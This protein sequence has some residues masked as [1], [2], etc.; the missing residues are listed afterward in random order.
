MASILP[1]EIPLTDKQ[2]EELERYVET[3]LAAALEAHDQR[4]EKYARWRKAYRAKPEVERKTFPWDG[5]SNMVIPIVGITVDT[6]VARLMRGFFSTPTPVEAQI[7]SVVA[8]TFEKDF[9]DWGELFFK[10]SGARDQTRS[11]FH[12]MTLDGTVFVKAAWDTEL[13]PVHAYNAEGGEISYTEVVDY[14]GVRWYA[15]PAHNMIYPTGFSEWKRLPWH[16]ERLMF[17]WAEL[18]ELRDKGYTNIDDQL[19]AQRSDRDSKVERANEETS[20]VSH[21]NPADFYEMFELWGKFPIP[22]EEIEGGEEPEPTWQECILTF[23]MKDRRLHRAI[24]N[25]FFGR[26]RCIIRIPFLH[27]PHEI[28]GLGAA[29]QVEQ[30]QVEA[31]TAH[32]QSID[33]AT[34]AI[35][36]IIVKKPNVTSL[37]G[38]SIHPGAELTADD[39]KND[40]MVIHL[41][42]GRSTLPGVEQQAAFWAEKRSGVSAY[43]MGVESG[44]AGSRATATGTTAL[45]SEGNMRF[46]VSI[47]DMREALVDLLYLT[48]Q[49]EQQYRPE[50]IPLSADRVLQLPQG[51]L[52][53]MFGLILHLSSEKI[54]RDLEIQNFQ[55]LITILNDYYARV[56]QAAALIMN[57][58]FP[59]GQ[60]F[61]IMQVMEAAHNLVKRLVERFDIQNIDEVVPGLTQALNMLGGISAPPP[62]PMGALPGG[63]PQ[64]P[65]GNPGGGPPASSQGS[66]FGGG[67]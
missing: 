5:A 3:Q 39:P 49:L 13:R 4:E 6:I 25:P 55:I 20:A 57:P 46:W 50:G 51:D 42:Q 61:I 29:E 53:E 26:A 2:R 58:A 64:G 65:P 66:E 36:G 15:I 40:I 38:K 11:C 19:K 23:S 63:A 52:R 35:A 24:Y 10:K 43:N 45:I 8:E 33:A 56:M 7:K 9:R 48:L 21:S 22:G 37:S 47:D 18:V 44:V 1:V 60:K 30:F 54:N 17:T 28:E 12:D 59:P 32:N 34:A 62:S 31:S 67:V 14:E 27:M 16:A 41:T